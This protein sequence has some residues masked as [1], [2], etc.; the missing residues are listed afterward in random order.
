MPS[1]A[2]AT[3]SGPPPTDPGR[4]TP[5]TVVLMAAVVGIVAVACA[6]NIHGA[7]TNPGPPVRAP[8]PGTAR[9]DVCAAVDTA[10]YVLLPVLVPVLLVLAGAAACGR[11]RR[12]SIA[13]L[14]AGLVVAVGQAATVG[15]L[16]YA[17]TI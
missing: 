13:A 7:C 1:A 11:R 3:A 4:L 9:A 6:L 17:T 14:I 8:E 2:P 12:P 10:G 15:S 5:G 16:D